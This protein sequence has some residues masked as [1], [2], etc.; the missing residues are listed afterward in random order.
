MGMQH[1]KAFLQGNQTLPIG[2]QANWSAEVPKGA[3]LMRPRL[4]AIQ[5][6]THRGAGAWFRACGSG[7]GPL[8]SPTT[9]L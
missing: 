7:K 4:P 9:S 2:T 8:M 5:L 6:V 1:E 3:A